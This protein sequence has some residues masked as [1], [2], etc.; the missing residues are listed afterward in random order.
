[1]AFATGLAKVIASRWA[2]T[3]SSLMMLIY[4]AAMPPIANK[5]EQAPN[6]SLQQLVVIYKGKG[7]RERKSSIKRRD[8]AKRPEQAE[9][10]AGKW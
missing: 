6:L 7:K 3:L 8:N 2:F 9:P 1:M 5:D 4:E 10:T